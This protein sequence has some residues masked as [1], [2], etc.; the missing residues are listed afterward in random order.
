MSFWDF[1]F[2]V[3]YPWAGVVVLGFWLLTLWW[4]FKEWRE[5]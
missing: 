2:E 4:G 3:I 5:G 1:I